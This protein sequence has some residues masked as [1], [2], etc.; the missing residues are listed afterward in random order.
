M[1]Y[2]GSRLYNFLSY[3][4]LCFQLNRWLILL[5]LSYEIEWWGDVPIDSVFPLIT[6]YYNCY[7]VFL[8]PVLGISAFF[9]FHSDVSYSRNSKSYKLPFPL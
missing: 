6:L 5:L 3:I 1:Q 2:E 9:F 7:T 4:V 8:L